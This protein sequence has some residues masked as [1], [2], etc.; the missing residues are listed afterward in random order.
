[1]AESDDD[2]LLEKVGRKHNMGVHRI[3]IELPPLNATLLEARRELAR[4]SQGAKD[5]TIKNKNVWKTIKQ[6]QEQLN[7]E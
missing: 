2:E 1:M 6:T 5:T 3:I 4:V 7:K